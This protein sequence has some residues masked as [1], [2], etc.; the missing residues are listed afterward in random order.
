MADSK[1]QCA[2]DVVAAL[3]TSLRALPD[4]MRDLTKCDDAARFLNALSVFHHRIHIQCLRILSE[5]EGK[6]QPQE[7]GKLERQKDNTN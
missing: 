1:N 7:R 6:P 5:R 2:L 3:A 4:A